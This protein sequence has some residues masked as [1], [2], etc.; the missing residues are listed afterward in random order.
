MVSKP[1]VEHWFFTIF[2]YIRLS[3]FI[4][5]KYVA[6]MLVLR[7]ARFLIQ[8]KLLHFS[9]VVIIVIIVI[10]INVKWTEQCIHC[11]LPV[12]T[13]M[14]IC[15][16]IIFYLLSRSRFQLI[17]PHSYKRLI[18][19]IQHTRQT[20]KDEQDEKNCGKKKE[21]EWDEK[22]A[23]TQII[24]RFNHEFAKWCTLYTHMQ[25]WAPYH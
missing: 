21:I 5:F 25:R 6:K 1:Y 7:L 11:V 15:T 17:L 12:L 22:S 14:C 8:T 3:S 20:N 13:W 16:Y 23:W 18:A 19:C 2:F 10:I 4:R 24:I 9:V